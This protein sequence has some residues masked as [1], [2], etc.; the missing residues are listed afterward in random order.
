MKRLV[1]RLVSQSLVLLFSIVFPRWIGFEEI[2]HR[3]HVLQQN[4]NTQHEGAERSSSNKSLKQLSRIKNWGSSHLFDNLSKTPWV[5]KT[6]DGDRCWIVVAKS[7]VCP[8]GHHLN[9]TYTPEQFGSNV[10]YWGIRM[11]FI[12]HV[13]RCVRTDSQSGM[14]PAKN[15]YGF[16]QTARAIIIELSLERTISP[17]SGQVRSTKSHE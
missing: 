12:E 8:L 3:G 16:D 1:L 13:F 14:Y 9:N 2:M 15:H 5:S 11:F 7:L 4:Q 17:R 6:V 10:H